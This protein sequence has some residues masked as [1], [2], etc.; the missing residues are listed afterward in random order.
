MLGIRGVHPFGQRD[1]T[2][3]IAQGQVGGHR[4]L[5]QFHVRRVTRK[6]AGVVLGGNLEIAVESCLPAGEIRP[7]IHVREGWQASHRDCGGKG[8]G[9]Q[10]K[11]QGASGKLA[12]DGS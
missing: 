2:A 1:R 11:H 4:R 6:G 8:K 7:R 10:T 9:G 3:E 12:F 5:H